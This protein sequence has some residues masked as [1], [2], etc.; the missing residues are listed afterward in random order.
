MFSSSR[1][2]NKREIDSLVK[3]GHSRKEIESIGLKKWKIVQERINK[4][5]NEIKLRE[6]KLRAEELQRKSNAEEEEKKQMALREKVTLEQKE[7]ADEYERRKGYVMDKTEIS[8]EKIDFT[9]GSMGLVDRMECHQA[10]TFL[11]NVVISNRP[12]PD[13]ELNLARLRTYQPS[14]DIKKLSLGD[15]QPI[16]LSDKYVE[17]PITNQ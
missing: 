14:N 17:F 6:Q 10:G 9:Q 1:R 15:I 3:Q 16:D 4:H 12:P 11:K 2:D 13:R 7:R 8:N 5:E